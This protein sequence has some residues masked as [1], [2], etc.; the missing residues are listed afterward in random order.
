MR[1]VLINYFICLIK[2]QSKVGICIAVFFLT[3]SNFVFGQYELQD[4]FPNLSFNNPVFLTH[5]DDNTNR[6]F[7]VEQ[8]GKIKVF[9][10]DQSASN[11]KVF[12]DLS[13]KVYFSGE[14][15][16][17]GLAFHP[18]YVNNGY[19]YVYYSVTNPFRSVISRFKVTSNPDSAD[20]NSEY[21]ILTFN[22]VYENHNG[23][24]MSFRKTDGYLYISTGDGGS[25][26]DPNNNAQNINVFLGKILRIDVDGGTPYAIPS[27]NP[28]YDSTN[29][30]IK[31]EIY[32]WGLRNPWRNSFDSVTDWFWCADVGQYEWEEINLIENGKNYGWRCYEGNHPYNTSGCNY[33]DYTY[34]IFEYSHSN[35]CS[36]TG[37]YVY[38][39]NSVPELYGKYI[40]GDYCSKKVWAL[41]YDGINP[42]TNQLLVTA[43]GLIT[44]FGVDENN[45]IYITSSNGIVYKFTPTV[46]CY[47]ID[48]KAGWNL[49]SVPLINNDMS[50]VNIFPNSS[51]QIFAYSD[52]YYV[53]DSLINGIGYWVNYSDNQT[54]QICGTEI[55]SSIS[56][57]SGWNLIGPFNH[58]VPV[59]NISSVPPN[60]IVSSFFEYNESYEIADTLNPGKGYWVK[61]SANGTI[62]FNQN[63]E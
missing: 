25:G 34:P 48:I 3:T 12:L 46:N 61:T 8:G 35:G 59:Q 43:S 39:G 28:F 5:A 40:Y 45:E 62:Q 14:M 31:K 50:S 57:S 20:K 10:N 55:S 49:V 6:V 47:N 18:D 11:A 23:G 22:K 51:S 44:S 63:A 26:G 19:F 37:G 30:S 58:P 32:A 16:L 27:T 21:Q 52:G 53:A 4:A 7:V 56:V 9:P 17:L 1:V 33:P 60:I 13:D 41:E 42:P 15:G 24:W 54:I 29:S 2:L 38:R 36:I